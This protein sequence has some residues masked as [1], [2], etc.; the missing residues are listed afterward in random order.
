MYVKTAGQFDQVRRLSPFPIIKTSFTDVNSKGDEVSLSSNLSLPGLIRATYGNVRIDPVR[1]QFPFLNRDNKD[2]DYDPGVEDKYVFSGW[3]GVENF[4]KHSLSIQE[5]IIAVA[6]GWLLPVMMDKTRGWTVIDTDAIWNELVTKGTI[7]GSVPSLSRYQAICFLIGNEDIIKKSSIV[8]LVTPGWWTASYAGKVAKDPDYFKLSLNAH[9]HA[10]K[11]LISSKGFRERVLKVWSELGD[12]MYTGTGYPFFDAQRDAEGRPTT[13][14]KTIDLFEN[15]QTSV[16]YNFADMLTEVDRRGGRFGMP[17]HPWAIMGIRRTSAGAKKTQWF[18][19]D[20]KGMRTGFSATGFNT[21]RL[22]FAVPYSYNIIISPFYAYLK[23]F[24]QVLPGAY[25]DGLSKQH[26][27]DRLR[28]YH[29]AGELWTLESDYKNYDRFAPT[30]ILMEIHHRLASYLEHG[31]YWSHALD[32]LQTGASLVWPDYHSEHKGVGYVFKPGRLGIMSGAKT[33]AEDGSILNSIMLG[34]MLAKVEQWS[35]VQLTD[36]LCQY[37]NADVGSKHEFYHLQGDDVLLY[38][39]S[40][41]EVVAMGKE[42]NI[43]AANAGLKSSL[44]PGDKFL[45]RQNSRGQDAPVP[46]RVRQNTFSNE[47]P[48]DSELVF[49]AGLVGRTDG[50][51]GIT[52]N[53][54]F[55]RGEVSAIS[56]VEAWF[57][58]IVLTE[59]LNA[60]STAAFP[61]PVAKTFLK[62]CLASIRPIPTSE[63]IDSG[64]HMISPDPSVARDLRRIRQH[65]IKELAASEL[66][67]LKLDGVV[68]QGS[69]LYELHKDSH[70]PSSQALLQSLLDISPE[71]A[72]AVDKIKGYESAFFQHACKKMGV[73]FAT[74]K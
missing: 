38:G 59:I 67:K 29:K 15:V 26:R 30:D 18:F 65:V 73:K 40:L 43:M 37:E 57:A 20:Y 33:T 5:S 44:V 11:R 24:R 36:Y 68:A 14:L 55:L 25:H 60:V 21:I 9:E 64:F 13:K 69:W 6:K 51:L 22:A 23:A 19:V 46:A 52:N 48:P 12:P 34:A 74:L 71:V 39:R 8:R 53:D 10:F 45:M 72:E 41:N 58:Q 3:K 31:E 62:L 35:E 1:A 27:L 50:L 66:A 7:G 61:S 28:S 16:G 4:L 47:T 70:S 56:K 17:G 54:P 42:F 49:L 32:F 2:R 63:V